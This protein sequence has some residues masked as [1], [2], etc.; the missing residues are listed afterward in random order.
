MATPEITANPPEYGKVRWTGLTATI[1]SDDEDDAPD[2]VILSGLVLFKPSVQAVAYPS[3]VPKFTSA[4]FN[5]KA[6]LVDGQIN[7]L[8]RDYIKLE[9]NSP[10]QNP[11]ELFWTATFVVSFNGAVAKIPDVKFTLEPNQEI[12]LTDLINS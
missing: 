6:E 5:R 10:G 12:D 9:A 8:G 4:L 3:A 2:R 7:E 11:E 1:D